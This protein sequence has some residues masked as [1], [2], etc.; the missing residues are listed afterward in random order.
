MIDAYRHVITLVPASAMQQLATEFLYPR[1]GR[2]LPLI[3]QSSPS[4]E[5]V[6]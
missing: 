6:S 3:K 5:E 2:P 4:N 1:N